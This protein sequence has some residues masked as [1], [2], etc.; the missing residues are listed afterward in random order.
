MV[1]KSCLTDYLGLQETTPSSSLRVPKQRLVY[2]RSRQDMTWRML[3]LKRI[4]F[5]ARKKPL[6]AGTEPPS[7]LLASPLFHAVDVTEE[8]KEEEL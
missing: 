7:A 1:S 8:L 2:M 6:P 4:D 3:D 5:L